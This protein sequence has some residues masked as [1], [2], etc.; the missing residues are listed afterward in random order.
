[1]CRTASAKAQPESLFG[2][3]EGRCVRPVGEPSILEAQGL[4]IS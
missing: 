2:G 3:V 1:M 4:E